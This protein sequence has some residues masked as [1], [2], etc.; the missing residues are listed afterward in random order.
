MGIYLEPGF[1]GGFIVGSLLT[2]LLGA[3]TLVL[4]FYLRMLAKQERERRG[5]S[6]VAYAFEEKTGGIVG[7]PLGVSI[8]LSE[9]AQ[10]SEESKKEAEHRG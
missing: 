5:K 1:K 6:P 7:N 9:W 3:L 10:V 4:C 8:P 2:L